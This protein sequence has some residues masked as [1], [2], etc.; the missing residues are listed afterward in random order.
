MNNVF[1]YRTVFIANFGM[2]I[3]KFGMHVSKFAT[4]KKE[5][6]ILISQDRIRAKMK[7]YL[8]F[9]SLFLKTCSHNKI[10]LWDV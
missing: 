5:D 2:Y 10:W 1:S 6:G 8:K 3:S 9:L 4:K 7:S